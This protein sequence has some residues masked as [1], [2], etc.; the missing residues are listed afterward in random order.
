M[1]DEA[2]AEAEPVVE[3]ETDD[4][5]ARIREKSAK[6]GSGYAVFSEAFAGEGV[7]RVVT[8]VKYGL[9]AFALFVVFY[10]ISSKF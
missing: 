7:T 6:F 9:A 5:I 3:A 8:I 1:S 4:T 2:K 10:A